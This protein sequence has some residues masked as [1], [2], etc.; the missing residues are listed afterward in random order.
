MQIPR[1]I[2]LEKTVTK[3]QLHKHT[4]AC[5]CGAV[6]FEVTA[7]EQVTVYECNCSI[8]TKSGYLHLEVEAEAFNWISG[9]D[10]VTIYTFNTGKAKH[11]FCRVCGIKAFYVPRSLPNGYSVNLN[12]LDQ[13]LIKQVEYI[14][15]DGENWEQGYAQTHGETHATDNEK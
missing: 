15:F 9:Q 10:M 12:C 2:R 7:P 5:H 6:Q 1:T 11:I 3:Q 4:G 13:S 8:C 14:P